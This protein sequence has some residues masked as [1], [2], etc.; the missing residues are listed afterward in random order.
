V[1]GTATPEKYRWSQLLP[2][3]EG[4]IWV[5]LTIVAFG[6]SL[7]IR[8]LIQIDC[9]GLWGDRPDRACTN[10]KSWQ[11]AIPIVVLAALVAGRLQL[12]RRATARRAARDAGR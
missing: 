1:T 9:N 7:L 2:I 3:L 10:A 8:L 4:L 5:I 12:H 11:V 6:S